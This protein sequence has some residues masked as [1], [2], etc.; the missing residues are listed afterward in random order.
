MTTKRTAEW[1]H[2]A[3]TFCTHEILD[4]GRQSYAPLEIHGRVNF[5]VGTRGPCDMP[6]RDEYRRMIS[7]WIESAVLPSELVA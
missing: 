4:G 7:D 1:G 6:R 5:P 2:W 3:I